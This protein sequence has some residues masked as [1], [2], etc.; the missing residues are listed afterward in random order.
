MR[1]DVCCAREPI[2][3]GRPSAC[4]AAPRRF[5]ALCGDLAAEVPRE[6]LPEVVEARSRGEL[7]A[8]RVLADLVVRLSE[9]DL[10]GADRVVLRAVE[11]DVAPDPRRV[12][13]PP[14]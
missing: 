13:P 9:R 3:P 1:E 12:V 10:L 8:L 6:L 14:A 7:V 11:R 2:G 5:A 4:V